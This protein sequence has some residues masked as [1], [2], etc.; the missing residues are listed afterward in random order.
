MVDVTMLCA[1]AQEVALKCA[2]V[3]LDYS[4]KSL[5]DVSKIISDTKGLYDKMIIDEPAVWNMSVLFGL[6][7]GEVMIRNN[8]EYKD[9]LV[10]HPKTRFISFTGSRDVGLRINERASK[11]NGGQD[12]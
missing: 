9:Y 6:Y 5:D 10:D 8:D 3:Q 7:T 11:L 2:Q 1:R 4:L 12:N